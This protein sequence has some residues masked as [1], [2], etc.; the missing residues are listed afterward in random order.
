[1]WE[2][3]PVKQRRV[4]TGGRR[5]ADVKTAATTDSSVVLTG[6]EAATAITQDV[7]KHQQ[8][9]RHVR[10]TI[11]DRIAAFESFLLYA[12][13]LE[14]E[15]VSSVPA[16]VK[17]AVVYVSTAIKDL[18]SYLSNDIS[19]LS[20][21]R[22]RA[23]FEVLKRT[24]K[25]H[26]WAYKKQHGKPI[27]AR[28][29]PSVEQPAQPQ[30][31]QPQQAVAGDHASIQAQLPNSSYKQDGASPSASPSS[32]TNTPSPKVKQPGV[33]MDRRLSSQ[34]SRAPSPRVRADMQKLARTQGLDDVLSTRRTSSA[35]SATRGGGVN[36]ARSNAGRSG[37]GDMKTAAT[38]L[39]GLLEAFKNQAMSTSA[40]KQKRVAYLKKVLRYHQNPVDP[41]ALNLKRIRELEN[42]TK[43]T[44]HGMQCVQREIA[45]IQQIYG[46]KVTVQ[47]N[48][49]HADENG[50]VSLTFTMVDQTTLVIPRNNTPTSQVQTSSDPLVSLH[51]QRLVHR[52]NCTNYP[53]FFVRI[54]PNA[55]NSA[56]YLFTQPNIPRDH[57]CLLRFHYSEDAATKPLVD[58][59]NKDVVS[60]LSKTFLDPSHNTI[61]VFVKLW[62]Y[63]CSTVAKTIFEQEKQQRQNRITVT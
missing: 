41:L 59:I 63:A 42:A 14:A 7:S 12:K 25:I 61:V 3:R 40:M 2:E 26:A 5:A 16:S 6:L 32:R 53:R 21:D 30:S 24:K 20:P 39:D 9:I 47:Y 8:A 37:G 13:Q 33:S 4:N 28:K 48:L 36:M 57:S 56:G 29:P 38:E 43:I 17:S 10:S 54:A 49:R 55:Y 58:K 23:F 35:G 51:G 1:M 52:P 22:N 45:K 62:Y 11:S 46:D 50:M 19:R 27:P 15:D 31:Q 34:R 60:G 18:Q 44:P